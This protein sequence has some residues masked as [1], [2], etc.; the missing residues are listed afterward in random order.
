MTKKF[1]LTIFKIVYSILTFGALFV[2]L[3]VCPPPVASA[4]SIQEPVYEVASYVE[5][6]PAFE[7]A[8]EE[9]PMIDEFAVPIEEPIIEEEMTTVYEVTV[10][11][12]SFIGSKDSIESLV[13]FPNVIPAIDDETLFILIG[14]LAILNLLG[15]NLFFHDLYQ[16]KLRLM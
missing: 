9:Q 11:S 13:V 1:W 12:P 8:L 2:A 4:D 10:P 14:I 3:F 7:P 15:L 5:E 16:V 6:S